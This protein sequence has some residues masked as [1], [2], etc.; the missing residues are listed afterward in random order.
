MGFGLPAAIGAALANPGIKAVCVTGDGSIQMNI[1]E[2]ATLAELGADVTVILLNNGHLGLV[3]QQQELFY[4]NRVF[5]ARFEKRADFTAI[6]RGFSV[7]AERAERAEEIA[8]LL[9]RAMSH[10]GP[11]LAEI[12]VDET[13]NVF[14]MV[15]PGSA[16]RN[17][18]GG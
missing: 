15:A 16:N 18:I 14:P 8:P 10:Q 17:M 13:A 3:R 9:E 5:A 7:D 11:F 2:L 4:G 12:M 6:A 1:Q